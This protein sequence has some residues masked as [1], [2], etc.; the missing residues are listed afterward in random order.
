[1]NLI[2]ELQNHLKPKIEKLSKIIAKSI[3]N[4]STVFWCGNSRSAADS[5]HLSA[6]LVG[7]FEQER[8]GLS[9]IALTADTS[10]F[11]SIGKDYSYYEIFFRQ[12]EALARPSDLLIAITTSEKSQNILKVLKKARS[13]KVLSILST[14][15]NGE[16]IKH[17]TDDYIIVPSTRTTRIQKSHMLIGHIICMKLI[18]SDSSSYI[19]NW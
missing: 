2:L 16:H 19:I 12:L 13:M 1:M 11:T 4:N 6:E 3:S 18:C 14:G 8:V 7:R 10:A 5:T 9:S 15:E 17:L